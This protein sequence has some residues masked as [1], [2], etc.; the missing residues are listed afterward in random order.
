MKQQ[1]C[2]D[3]KH[4]WWDRHS[5]DMCGSEEAKKFYKVAPFCSNFNEGG[6]CMFFEAKEEKTKEE[7]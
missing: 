6:K 4:V 5:P 7:S 3:C 2:R 1:D